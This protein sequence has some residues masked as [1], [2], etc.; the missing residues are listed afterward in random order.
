M[1]RDHERALDYCNAV[2]KEAMVNVCLHGMANEYRV[3]LK[4]LTF[5]YFS[6]LMEAAR[7]MKE[8][9]RRTP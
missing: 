2:N 9:V 4:N 1:S 5:L 7:R 8:T 3:Y 6:K